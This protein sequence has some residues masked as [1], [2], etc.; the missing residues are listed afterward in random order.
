MWGVKADKTVDEKVA[1]IVSLYHFG[2]IPLT[3]HKKRETIEE[4]EKRERETIEE[5]R[6]REKRERKERE[7]RE[8]IER[9][10]E[11]DRREEVRTILRGVDNSLLHAIVA[12]IRTYPHSERIVDAISIKGG[13]RKTK[14]GGWPWSTPSPSKED[15][16]AD[17]ILADSSKATE[18][19][20]SPYTNL[21]RLRKKIVEKD[22]EKRMPYI[23]NHI[24]Y[25]M[26][27]RRYASYQNSW[28]G[29]RN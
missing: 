12:K 10:E 4:R 22:T 17:Q 28:D 18:I 8:R 6:E 14:R 13:K 23:L 11:L 21:E 5:K 19:I 16:F 3:I 7:D 24:D 20:R 1:K 9:D 25:E 27:A 2:H 26:K 29:S 15:V